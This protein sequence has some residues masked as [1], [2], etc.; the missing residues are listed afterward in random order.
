MATASFGVIEKW[1]KT[2]QPFEGSLRRW[3]YNFEK[4][5]FLNA[6]GSQKEAK[7][8]V[9]VR[10]GQS[11]WNAQGRIQGISNHSVTVL[12]PKAESQA[13]TAR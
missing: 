2:N 10:H 6:A 9:L 1:K 5:S 4:K 13:E 12:T 3:S 8:V 7:R 11:T